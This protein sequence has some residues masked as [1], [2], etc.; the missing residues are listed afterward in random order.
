VTVLSRSVIGGT[1]T[2]RLLRFPIALAAW[3]ALVSITAA[4]CTNSGQ[5]GAR[6]AKGRPVKVAGQATA[7]WTDNTSPANLIESTAYDP[8]P[9]LLI[10]ETEGLDAP[11]E[12]NA[13]STITAVRPADGSV[14]WRTPVTGKSSVMADGQYVI[15]LANQLDILSAGTGQLLHAFPVATPDPELA[16]VTGDNVVIEDDGRS[17]TASD[18]AP[19]TYAVSLATGT[20]VWERS[21][22]VNCQINSGISPPFADS[23]VVALLMECSTPEL[24][25]VVA[26]DPA[27]GKTMWQRPADDASI[28]VRNGFIDETSSV[29]TTLL[30]PAGNVVI[31]ASIKSQSQAILS[32]GQGSVLL[33]YQNTGGGFSVVTVN[34]A[35]EITHRADVNGY[36]GSSIIAAFL[37]SDVVLLELVLPKTLLPTGLLQLNLRDGSRSLSP[38]PLGGRSGSGSVPSPLDQFGGSMLMSNVTMDRLTAFKVVSPQG[39]AAGNR[40]GVPVLGDTPARWP[41]ACALIPHGALSSIVTGPV[42]TI[43]EGNSGSDG[44]P[45]YSTCEYTTPS[46]PVSI[47]VS[48]A[49]YAKS[50]GDAARNFDNFVG[51]LG[52]SSHLA[53]PWDEGW[54]GGPLYAI[55][56]YTIFR[57]GSIIID[58]YSISSH[59][60]SE[61]L[62]S[63]IAQNLTHG[64]L[65]R[66]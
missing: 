36:P 42:T 41:N 26:L 58:I 30:A 14:A 43:R 59:P 9:G 1:L 17:L 16:G 28:H 27:S 7:A 3:L 57:V 54:Y 24:E 40:T 11:G 52:G 8:S 25:N 13:V 45:R 20:I 2:S 12:L 35:G 5:T 53:G 19:T 66:Q 51:N 38:L 55:P 33:S 4:A 49:W 10:Y 39:Q 61:M 31:T 21:W 56:D 48:V 60:V 34:S 64:G 46:G 47:F 50:S 65:L 18:I 15:V 29:S 22:G 23:S 63:A 6:T 62:A 44:L 32:G 37:A